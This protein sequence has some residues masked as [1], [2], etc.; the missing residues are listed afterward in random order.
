VHIEA[1][2][3]R[4]APVWF[5]INPRPPV[6]AKSD[7]LGIGGF[8]WN[9]VYAALLFVAVALAVRNVRRGSG[10]A[11][12]A[13]RAALVLGA[14]AF[15]QR[16][17]SAH[18]GTT[19]F[20]AMIVVAGGAVYQAAM[21]CLAYM[22]V[23]P[24]VRRHWPALLISWQR[25]VDLRWRDPLVGRDAGIGMLSGI[26]TALIVRAVTVAIGA[27]TPRMSSARM[28][29]M[30]SLTDTA[31]W[32]AHVTPEAMLYALWALLFLV[33]G[34]VF[35]RHPAIYAPL[36]VLAIGLA[37]S[38]ATGNRIAD[39]ACGLLCSIG[40]LVI[41][42]AGGM[43]AACTSWIC[44]HLLDGIPVTLDFHAWFAGRGLFV[45]L[46]LTA[47]AAYACATALAPG[48]RFATVPAIA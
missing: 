44:Y 39:V 26:T 3:F 18:F 20:D 21:F 41:L 46:L 33:C 25:L 17:F 24:Y 35:I 8:A 13:R 10:D 40:L 37:V 30:S 38:P 1:A 42:R 29:T 27:S 34:R 32:I 19:F 36:F 11:R 45:M 12:G 6:R 47:M 5:A 2:T 4:G 22:A 15:A 43:L 28:A 16:Y 23:E 14:C 31:A 7:F 9:F 48:R